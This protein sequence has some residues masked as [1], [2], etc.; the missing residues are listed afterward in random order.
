MKKMQAVH[1]NHPGDASQLYLQEV[2][3]PQWG[4]NEVLLRVHYAGVNRPDILQRLGKYPPPPGASPYLGLE[5]AGI[6]V[7]CGSQVQGWKEGDVACALVAGGAY[8]EYCV[9]PEQQ[10][11]PL[12]Q[13]LSMLE[14]AALPET[15]FTVWTNLYESARLKV[16]ESL[17][18]HGGSGGI[19]TAAIQIAKA[20]GSRVFVTAGSEEKCQKCR[21]LGAELAVNYRKHD[22]VEEVKAYTEGKGVDVILDMVGGPYLSKNISLLAFQGRMVSI[23]FLQGSRA[24]IDFRP[25]LLNQ[26]VLTGSTLRARPIEEKGR[27]AKELQTHLWPLLEAG[28]IAPVIDKVY[29]LIEVAQAHR[30]M[31]ANAHIGK[32]VLEM[33]KK[34]K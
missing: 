22:F 11:L 30:H 26:L 12:P 5:G 21:N 31:E 13:G 23:A 7:A 15:F 2:P 10:L 24:E 27:I 6:V 16:G 25:I 32:I 20:R 33:I 34:E 18:V 29:P 17:L 4:E 14:A 1:F 9:V 19:G 8:A 3:C 28:L